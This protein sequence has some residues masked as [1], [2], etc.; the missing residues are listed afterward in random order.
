[1]TPPQIQA[2]ARTMTSKLYNQ[3]LVLILISLRG[4]PDLATLIHLSTTLILEL[5][6]AVKSQTIHN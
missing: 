3:E 5:E 6:A 2:I 4:S 1:M